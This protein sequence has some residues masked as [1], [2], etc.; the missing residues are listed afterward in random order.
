MGSQQCSLDGVVT[1]QNGSPSAQ[2]ANTSSGIRI[3][4]GSNVRVRNSVTLGNGLHGIH[5]AA[6]GLAVGG[7]SVANIDLGSAAGP[8]LNLVQNDNTQGNINING[9]GICFET[10]PGGQ[11]LRLAAQGNTFSGG[12]KCT[13]GTPTLTTNGAMKTCAG[14][15]DVGTSSIAGAILDVTTCT[16]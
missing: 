4:E 9:V 12:V 3:V 6:G 1:Y 5:I 16:Y 13:A 7:A 8:G 15:K 11:P 2:A 14:A 10:S